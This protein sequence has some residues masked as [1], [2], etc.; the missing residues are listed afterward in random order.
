MDANPTHH[1]K[2][3][4]LSVSIWK[5]NGMDISYEVGWYTYAIKMDE[6]LP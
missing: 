4:N 1:W 3:K 6:V 5:D 2:Y